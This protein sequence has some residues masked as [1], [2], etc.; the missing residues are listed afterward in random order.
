MNGQANILVVDDEE[1]TLHLLYDSLTELGHSVQ[2]AENGETGLRKIRE[3]DFEVL[4]TDLKMPGMDGIEV[5]ESGKKINPRIIPIVMSGFATINTVVE[6]MRKGAVDYI[7]KPLDVNRIDLVIRRTLGKEK[8]PA[9]RETDRSF[10]EKN[11][12]DRIIGRAPVMR[13]I[14]RTIRQV[15]NSK[16]TV[17]LSGESGT[18]KELVARAIHNHSPRHRKRF[19]ALNCGALPETLLESELFGHIKGAFTGAHVNKHGLFEAANGGTFFLD[20]VADLSSSLQVKLLRVIQEREIKP[21]GGTNTTRVDVR[22][23]A[24]TNRDLEQEIVKGR[25]REDLFYRLNVIPIHLPPLRERREDIPLL[26]RHFL[27]K[28]AQNTEAGKRE[29]SEEAMD[30]LMNYSWPGNV[31]ELENVIERVITLEVGRVLRIE[32][33]PA[34]IQQ[35]RR[36]VAFRADSSKPS[37]YKE[38]KKGAII[39]FDREFIIETL[40]ENKG[41]VTRASREVALTRR[42]FQEK[43]KTCGIKSKNYRQ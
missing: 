36:I 34:N 8:S 22:L 10:E 2:L 27:D 38:A 23:I 37:T 3:E 7:A 32:G 19:L 15:A 33:L 21:V 28:Y 14:Y 24:A 31:R 43:M 6:A 26:I 12:F 29:V 11:S 18:G 1:D 40:K 25:F 42:A 17:L 16:T 9:E 30:L 20:E 5:I 41:N 35:Y 4:L 39:S 13:R